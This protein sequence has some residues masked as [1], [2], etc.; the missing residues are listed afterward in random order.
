MGCK[1]RRSSIW[2]NGRSILLRGLSVWPISPFQV[3]RSSLIL[4]TPLDYELGKSTFIP[5]KLSPSRQVLLPALLGYLVQEREV[6]VMLVLEGKVAT[7]CFLIKLRRRDEGSAVWVE[8]DL[9]LSD[10]I[11]ERRD[12]AVEAVEDSRNATIGKA[13]WPATEPRFVSRSTYMHSARPSL[14]Q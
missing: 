9:V 7:E 4:H 3:R 1:C 10:R 8:S 13:Q 5:A 12:E 11:D 6:L 14:S 2:L